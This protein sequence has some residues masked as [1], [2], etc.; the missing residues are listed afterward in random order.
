M[1]LGTLLPA[2]LALIALTDLVLFRAMLSRGR[3]GETA[4]N[5]MVLAAL[6][7]PVLAYVILNVMLPE[8][9]RIEVL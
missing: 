7:L 5:L 4:F 9:G 6:S 1:S 2:L 8:W 3:I